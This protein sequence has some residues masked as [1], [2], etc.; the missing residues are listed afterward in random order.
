MSFFNTKREVSSL[1][2]SGLVYVVKI[3]TKVYINVY[4]GQKFLVTVL[5]L[6]PSVGLRW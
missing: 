4:K 3:S 5:V 6:S 1:R 2:Q